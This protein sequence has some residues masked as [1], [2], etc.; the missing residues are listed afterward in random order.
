MIKKV[1]QQIREQQVLAKKEII[2]DPRTMNTQLG[3]IKRAEENLNHLF[4]DLRNEVK[5]NMVLMLVSGKHAEDFA[6]IAEESFSCI[7]LLA[8]GVFKDM[9]DRVDDSFLG[10]P[11]SPTILDIAMGVM[12]D[13]S[14]EIGIL[15]FNHV[16]FKT[17]EDSVQLNNRQ[18]LVKMIKNSFNRDVGSELVVIKAIHDTSVKIMNSEF[19]GKKVPVILFSEDKDLIDIIEKDSHN[20]I[21]KSFKLNINKKPTLESVENKLI[22]LSKQS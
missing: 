7:S 6:K 14:H 15:G 4:I 3:N 12:S 17:A 19:E 11:A 21:R 18:D 2:Q 1:I 13:L 10:K 5:N 22:E 9:A 16:N 20:V 8:E